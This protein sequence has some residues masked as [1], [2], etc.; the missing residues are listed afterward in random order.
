MLWD[1]GNKSESSQ[2]DMQTQTVKS[3]FC[4]L[5]QQERVKRARLCLREGDWLSD[6]RQTDA[7]RCPSHPPCFGGGRSTCRKHLLQIMAACV[8]LRRGV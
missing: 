8:L 5:V 2:T 7:Y 1:K 6:K 4:S 3:L